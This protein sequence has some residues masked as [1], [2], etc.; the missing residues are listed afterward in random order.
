MEGTTWVLASYDGPIV[1]EGVSVDLLLE[2]GEASGNSGCNS[3][4]GGYELAGDEL[5][6]GPMAATQM[7]CP[8]EQM[9][10]EAAYLA[11]L[12]RTAAYQ[13]EGD[14]LVLFDPRGTELLRFTE[15]GDG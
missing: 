9:D 6:F 8:P 3:Y 12:E 4:S 7:A 13:M 14:E 1:P 2:Q 10:V 5:A 11:A 15:V